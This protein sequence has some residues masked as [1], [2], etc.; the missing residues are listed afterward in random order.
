MERVN[1]MILMPCYGG[2]PVETVNSLMGAALSL[3]LRNTKFTSGLSLISHARDKLADEFLKSDCTHA[4]FIDSD[5]VFTPHDVNDL[6][7]ED[8]PIVGGLACKK[9]DGE[10]R[11]A[12]TLIDGAE[13]DERGLIEAAATG[14][15]FVAIHRGVF[16]H[17][18][19]HYGD[20]IVYLAGGFK[21]YKLFPEYEKGKFQSEDTGFCY[22]A[23][24]LGYN[25]MLD[26]NV[27]VGHHGSITF[28]V[29]SQLG[30]S[31]IFGYNQKFELPLV[32][33][34]NWN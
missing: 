27:R 18:I 1:P 28:P 5:M 16:E 8:L 33:G 6:L 2:V 19:E 31:V 15:A 10:I 23:R 21:R 25:I 3:G 13:I 17:M 26:T 24:E 22:R 32:N 7:T 30:P 4:F 11:V 20:D 12:S 14:M 9:C 29:E 34:K